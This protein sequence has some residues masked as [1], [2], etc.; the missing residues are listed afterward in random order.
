MNPTERLLQLGSSIRWGFF[1]TFEIAT[2][3][4]LKIQAQCDMRYKTILIDDEPLALQRLERLLQPYGDLIE[5]VDRATNGLEAVEKI[6]ATKPDLI[7]LDIQMPALNGFE[8][9]DHL[10]HLPW[11]IFSTAYDEYALK[12][13]ETNSI[14]YLLK[15]VDPERLKKALEKLQ[16]LTGDETSAWREQLQKLLAGVKAPAAKRIQVRLGDHIR[17]LNLKDI[18][19]FRAVDKYVEAHTFDESFLL[20]ET[21]NQFE[22]D[23]P[24]GDFVRIH[25]SALINLNHLDE[26]VRLAPGSYRARMRDKKKTELPVSR[27]AKAK[28]G[29]A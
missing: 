26:V 23:L 2:C 27:G 7:F 12:A 20:T 3:L 9:L 11:I 18:Y 1:K 21:L 15:P 8:V 14:D 13:F 4:R 24:A 22:A 25:R 16:R 17:F 5:I 19:F 29:L 10:T 28:L 6:D